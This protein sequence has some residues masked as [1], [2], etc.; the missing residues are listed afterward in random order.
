[1]LGCQGFRFQPG[2]ALL[3]AKFQVL[4]FLPCQRMGRPGPVPG[5]SLISAGDNFYVWMCGLGYWARGQTTPAFKPEFWQMQMIGGKWL[6]N[7]AV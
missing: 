2:Q 3:A 4:D 1:L 6:Y 5:S 7:S